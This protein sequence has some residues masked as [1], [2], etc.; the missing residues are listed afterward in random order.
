MKGGNLHWD[1][2]S[3]DMDT[4]MYK[5]ALC[6]LDYEQNALRQRISCSGLCRKTKQSKTKTF[7]N[8]KLENDTFDNR[9]YKRSTLK[10]ENETSQ[11][12]ELENETRAHLFSLL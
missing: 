12:L 10:F 5:Q 11:I 2:H 3:G 7:K 8:P 9:N 1:L 6:G 4:E